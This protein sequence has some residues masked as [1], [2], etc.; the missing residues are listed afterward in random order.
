M[1]S[2]LPQSDFHSD[3]EPAW[4]RD[5]EIRKD[6]GV[7]V[8]DTIEWSGKR[9]AADE[10]RY[11]PIEFVTPDGWDLRLPCRD[12]KKGRVISVSSCTGLGTPTMPFGD[13]A[14]TYLELVEANASEYLSAGWRLARADFARDVIVPDSI[15][16]LRDVIVRATASS[17]QIEAHRKS[18]Q[19]GVTIL[20]VA[21]GDR[22]RI[23]HKGLEHM[24]KH[25]SRR[26]VGALKDVVRVELQL[27]K[28]QL[29]ERQQKGVTALRTARVEHEP[30][31]NEP[32]V[33]R[34]KPAPGHRIQRR[35]LHA[36]KRDRLPQ[37][38]V[39]AT[40][41]VNTF[42]LDLGLDRLLPDSFGVT[43]PEPAYGTVIPHT[44]G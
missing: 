4:K 16:Y 25:Q 38:A 34:L 17:H 29:D 11:R 30:T 18:R 10:T 27:R 33:M 43:L 22:L 14:W 23:Y 5:P 44:A 24:N 6:R 20:G 37:R 26:M 31:E 1:A 13:H 41:A 12:F 40:N 7:L 9:P 32:K 15:A 39:E 3:G 42:L 28:G 36:M 35:H 2:D 21:G 19:L 8:P